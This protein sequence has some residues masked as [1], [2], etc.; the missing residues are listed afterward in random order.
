MGQPG[1]LNIEL[2]PSS[3]LFLRYFQL[4]FF[5]LTDVG[6]T[7]SFAEV[8]EYIVLSLVDDG[9]EGIDALLQGVI[10]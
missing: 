10:R 4:T 2:H 1:Y 7:D 6:N 9:L 5:K 3:A 8:L